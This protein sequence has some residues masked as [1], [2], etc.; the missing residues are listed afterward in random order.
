MCLN[1]EQ[2]I[3]AD[4]VILPPLKDAL[5]RTGGYFASPGRNCRL[6]AIL[7]NLSDNTV[8]PSV[9]GQSAQALAD[10]AGIVIPEATRLIILENRTG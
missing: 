1:G 8:N 6:T 4:A 10:L 5:R 2:I 3:C 9:I 7:A